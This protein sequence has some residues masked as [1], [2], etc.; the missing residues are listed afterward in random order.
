MSKMNVNTININ[1]RLMPS[2]AETMI[3]PTQ[4]AIT[5]Y[6]QSTIALY[7]ALDQLKLCVK[8]ISANP[9]FDKSAWSKAYVDLTRTITAFENSL[10]EV[11]PA[12]L[13]TPCAP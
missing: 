5:D 6:A 9:K 10:D 3:S 8:C 11:L 4:L 1:N 7:N 12:S 2:D 13:W